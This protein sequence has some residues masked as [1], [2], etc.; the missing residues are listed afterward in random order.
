MP[1]HPKTKKEVLMEEVL[2]LGKSQ[3]SALG[4]GKVKTEPSSSRGSEAQVIRPVGRPPQ[5]PTIPFTL[6]LSRE[7]AERLQRLV[8]DLQARAVRG[9]LPRKDA[10]L[11]AVVEEGLRLYERK[12]GESK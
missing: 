9:E 4:S 8:A 5:G 1:S 7:S 11:A 10:T 12:Y 3:E 2:G 6:R